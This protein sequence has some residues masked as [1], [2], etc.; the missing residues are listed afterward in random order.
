MKCA[1]LEL[2]EL[3]E[4]KMEGSYGKYYNSGYTR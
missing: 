4:I 2:F 3:I 1:F